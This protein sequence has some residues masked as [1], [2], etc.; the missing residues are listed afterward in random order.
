MRFN[1]INLTEDRMSRPFLSSSKSPAWAAFAHATP[2][3]RWAVA[4]CLLLAAFIGATTAIAPVACDV[5]EVAS[6][7]FSNTSTNALV[8]VESAKDEGSKDQAKVKTQQRGVDDSDKFKSHRQAPSSSK[9]SKP[10]GN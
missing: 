6:Y 10:K 5:A 7:E 1:S 3:T 4:G 8:S 9:I 2:L